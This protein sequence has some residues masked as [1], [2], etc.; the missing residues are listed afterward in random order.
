M[1]KQQYYFRNSGSQNCYRLEYHL[2]EAHDEGLTDVTLIEAIPDPHNP[3]YVYCTNNETIVER[4]GCRK[5]FCRCYERRGNAK[6][7][8]CAQRGRLYVHGNE[9][10]L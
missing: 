5:E 9:K 6:G 3:D 8:C 2:K 10:N 7:G 1:K 4:D